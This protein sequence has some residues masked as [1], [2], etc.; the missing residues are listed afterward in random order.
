MRC[1]I[2]LVRRLVVQ[3]GGG[4]L[5]E[6]QTTPYPWRESIAGAA[7]IRYTVE[8]GESTFSIVEYY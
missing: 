6:A 8:M 2:V 5:C 1:E 4:S 7:R 3:S